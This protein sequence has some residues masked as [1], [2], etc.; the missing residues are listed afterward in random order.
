MYI[1]YVLKSEN[2]KLY[3]GLTNNLNRRLSEHKRG[4]TIT[5]SKINNLQ[6]VYT[7]SYNTFEEAR[8]REKYFKSAVGRKFIKRALSSSG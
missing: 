5:T 3:K 7:E 6:V 8:K 2:G 1:V 4:H